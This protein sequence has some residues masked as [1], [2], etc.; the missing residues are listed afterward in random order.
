M[1]GLTSCMAHIVQI[2]GKSQ[3]KSKKYLIAEFLNNIEQA[4]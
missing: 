3:E 2:C 1:F 4:R